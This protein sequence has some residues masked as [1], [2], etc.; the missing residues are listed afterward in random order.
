MVPPEWPAVVPEWLACPERLR[1]RGGYPHGTYLHRVMRGDGSDLVWQPLDVQQTGTEEDL[2]GVVLG[3]VHGGSKFRSP[4]LSCCS[5]EGAAK[6]KLERARTFTN[7]YTGP[8][9]DAYL[10][11]IDVSR[12]HPGQVIFFDR[13][14][15]QQRLVR[16]LS[17]S[18]RFG[19]FFAELGPREVP[20]SKQAV[21]DREVLLVARG[22]IQASLFEDV[23]LT[24]TATRS[25]TSQSAGPY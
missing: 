16:D 9:P 8:D 5:S 23:T 13:M 17:F 4:L 20:P 25:R 10:A 15:S 18:D 22:A 6:R 2:V 14:E 19:W 21:L 3:A 24:M 12:L 1:P 7:K 11:R